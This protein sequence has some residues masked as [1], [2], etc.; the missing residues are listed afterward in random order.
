MKRGPGEL[1]HIPGDG[2]KSTATES[3]L[4][5]IKIFNLIKKVVMRSTD[6]EGLINLRQFSALVNEIRMKI[7]I[8]VHKQKLMSTKK[9][10][11]SRRFLS[12][13]G[14]ANQDQGNEEVMRGL[15]KA[16]KK[17]QQK[18]LKDFSLINPIKVQ[19]AIEKMDDDGDE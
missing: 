3:P 18:I 14:S 17:I 7:N 10:S 12:F 13:R 1:Q 2:T 4:T 11:G 5:R 8:E 16:L 15:P 19:E 6:E 9:A